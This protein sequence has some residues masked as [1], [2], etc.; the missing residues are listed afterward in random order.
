MHNVMVRLWGWMMGKFERKRKIEAGDRRNCIINALKRL[1]NASALVLISS[2]YV[3][4][5]K[6]YFLEGSARGDDK[7][8]QDH[9]IYP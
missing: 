4:L 2:A 8:L 7:K 6:K 3:R 9:N 1:Y 5:K